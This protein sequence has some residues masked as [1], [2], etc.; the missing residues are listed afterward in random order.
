MGSCC[1]AWPSLCMMGLVPMGIVTRGHMLSPGSVL[2]SFALRTPPKDSWE[3]L[4]SEV[5]PSSSES[6]AQT[7]GDREAWGVSSLGSARP[8]CMGRRPGTQGWDLSVLRT[9]LV[10][11]VPRHLLT[12]HPTDRQ[13]CSGSTWAVRVLCL[14]GWACV[15]HHVNLVEC[16]STSVCT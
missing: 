13:Q 15:H 3:Y 4:S 14:S 16:V 6:I 10:H 9:W 8:H 2:G 11:L 7:Q 5:T 1:E 12:L